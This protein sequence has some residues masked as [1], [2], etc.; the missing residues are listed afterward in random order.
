MDYDKGRLRPTT[1][2]E[3]QDTSLAL[4]THANTDRPSTKSLADF[5]LE[6][7]KRL[8]VSKS[9]AALIGFQLLAICY[10]DSELADSQDLAERCQAYFDESEHTP[11]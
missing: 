5:E 4:L 11:N 8:S 10:R 3:A 7:G 9:E 1:A 6:A 2:Q